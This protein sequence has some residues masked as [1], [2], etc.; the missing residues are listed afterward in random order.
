MTEEEKKAMLES[1]KTQNKEQIESF[2]A[3]FKQLAEDA[4]KGL[5]T[6]EEVENILN[7]NFGYVC[8]EGYVP[9]RVNRI[10][11]SKKELIK[12]IIPDTTKRN[13]NSIFF[14]KNITLS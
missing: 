13:E 4:K 1:V 3:E 7:I 10:Y 9:S 8:L 2:K 11:T 12:Q 6:K 5:L 14:Q